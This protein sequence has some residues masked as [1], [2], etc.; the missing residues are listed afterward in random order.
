MGVGGLSTG[1]ATGIDYGSLLEGLLNLEQR[2]I[3]SLEEKINLNNLKTEAYDELNTQ[4][5]GAKLTMFDFASLSTFEKKTV[6]SSNESV[7]TASADRTAATGSHTLQ[8]SRLASSSVSVSDGVKDQDTTTLNAG[9]L[10]FELG[11]RRLDSSM[12]LDDLNDGQGIQRGVITLTDSSGRS[13]N[14]DLASAVT[15]QDMLDLFNSNGMGLTISTDRSITAAPADP[16]ANGY[17]LQVVNGSSNSVTLT[18]I[19][20]SSTL[21]DLGFKTSTSKTIGA[22]K[23]SS[24]L[25]QIHYLTETTKLNQVNDGFGILTNTSGT[26]DMRFYVKNAVTSSMKAIEVDLSS[27]QNVGDVVN[28]INSALFDAQMNQY[29]TARL[30]SDGVSL[31]FTGE[32][33]GFT[34]INE[35]Q[36]ATDLGLDKIEKVGTVY[37]GEALI[38]EMGSS[39]IRNLKGGHGIDGL[40]TGTFNITSKRG[41]VYSIQLDRAVNVSDI[42]NEINNAVANDNNVSSLL[43]TMSF[44]ATNTMTDSTN[45]IS[46]S[47]TIETDRLIGAQVLAID[48]LGNQYTAT[49][50]SID[51]NTNTITF[52]SASDQISAVSGSVTQYL[53]RYQN[54]SDIR[55]EINENG[56]G[57]SI[58]DDSSGNKTFRVDDI[59]GNVAKQLGI[60]TTLKITPVLF[61]PANIGTDTSGVGRRSALYL[62]KGSLPD[63]ITEA[64][65]LGRSVENVWSSST[66]QG[67]SSTAFSETKESAKIIAFEKAPDAFSLSPV[68]V[69]ASSTVS[70]NGAT[71]TTVAAAT[72]QT[73][74]YNDGEDVLVDITNLTTSLNTNLNTEFIVGSTVSVYHPTNGIVSS[75]VI[76]YDSTAKSLTFADDAFSAAGLTASDFETY[77]YNVEYN[78]KIVLEH[79]RTPDT[80]SSPSNLAVAANSITDTVTTANNT[81]DSDRVNGATM[82][83]YS[84]GTTTESVITGYT[85]VDNGDGT[86]NRSFTLADTNITDLGLAAINTAGFTVT[87]TPMQ[88]ANFSETQSNILS[89]HETQATDTI[90]I[91]GVGSG[92]NI[93]GKNLDNRMISGNT[94]LDD[95]NGGKGINKGIMVISTGDSNAEIDLNQA[96]IQ[97]VQDLINEVTNKFASV[98]LEIND[99]GDGLRIYDKSTSPT[100]GLSVTDKTGTAAADLNLLN[101][102]LA[103]TKLSVASGQDFYSLKAT[104][105][106]L[107]NAGNFITQVNATGLGQQNKSDMI[108]SKISY[109]DSSGGALNGKTIHAIIA[110][111]S[112]NTSTSTTTFTLSGQST[113]SH[114]AGIISDVSQ[115]TT[116]TSSTINI[117]DTL[118]IR[119]KKHFSDFESFAS[120]TAAAEITLGTDGSATP[121]AMELTLNNSTITSYANLSEEDLIGSM[122]NFASP[123]SSPALQ[124]GGGITA[125]IT[126]FDSANNKLYVQAADADVA[127][128]KSITNSG[129]DMSIGIS[130]DN[131]PKKHIQ[132]GQI[133]NNFS[134]LKDV[135]TKGYISLTAQVTGGSSNVITSDQ[136]AN[137]NPEDV[138]GALVTVKTRTSSTTDVGKVA[139][140]TGYNAAAKSVTVGNY[141]TYD[142]TTGAATAGA[143]TLSA[144]DEIYVTYAK[145]LEGAV[146]RSDS[147]TSITQASTSVSAADP[148]N[149]KLLD[150]GPITTIAGSEDAIIGATITFGSA[151]TTTALQNE[152]RKI[153]DILHDYG[154]TAGNTVLVLD[155]ALPAA[156]NIT[157]ASPFTDETFIISFNEITATIDEVDFSTGVISTRE[158]LE[159]GFGTRGFSIHQ[160]IDGSY[161]KEIEVLETDTLDDLTARINGANM[162]VRASVI[163]DGSSSNPFRLSLTSENTGDRGAVTVSSD[164]SDF[165]LNVASKGQDAKIIIGDAAGNSSVVTSSTNTVTGAIA[166]VTLNLGQAS[167]EQVSLT[168]D[169]DKEGLQEKAQTL[170]D[171][172]NTLLDSASKLIALE[173]VVEVTQ[174]DGTVRNE[175]QKGLLFGDAATR[176]M[177]NDIKSLLT[178]SVSG[179]ASG[180]LNELSDVGITLASD[181]KSF[182]FDT[183][184]FNSML[185]SKFDEVTNLFTTNPNLGPGASLNV[186]SSFLQSNYNINH[187]RNGDTSKSGFSE[188]GN[189]TNGI[190]LQAG[191]ASKY[192]TY[193]FGEQKDLY[194]FRLH[195]YVPSD[196]T[197]RYSVGTNSSTLSGTTLTDLT[198]LGEAKGLNSEQVVGA[199]LTIGTSQATVTGY[200][201]TTGALTLDTSITG[202]STDGYILTTKNGQNISF[203]HNVVVEY[204]DP[205]TNTYKTYQTYNSRTDG[206]MSIVFPGQLQTDSL[207]IRYNANTGDSEDFTNNGQYVRLLEM[208]VLDSQGIGSQFSRTFDNF[209]NANTGSI[210]IANKNLT[211]LNESYTKQIERL[212]SSLN[213]SQDRY[214][215]QFQNLE[216]V[217]SQLNSQSQYLQSQLGSLPTAFSYRGNNG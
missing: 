43:N 185:S 184:L 100:S 204:R 174:E 130:R 2:P 12:L 34:N 5:L 178:A 80:T 194:G 74:I 161:Q 94:R 122:I 33:S 155:E 97:T 84:G 214:I 82:T 147:K 164:I 23:T 145:E 26:N 201:A 107:T 163:S 92:S 182:D 76:K 104:A 159:G 1:L 125:M 51:L 42:L 96:T 177:I 200:N 209:T 197:A 172:V 124:G 216:Q 70:L 215:K 83:V 30:S 105:S 190:K 139:V 109:V 140:I 77:G 207:R 196:L 193:T 189:G 199:T 101:T 36:A 135:T 98:R 146:L 44:T 72:S 175:K 186:S 20:T 75:T 112:Y 65:L 120:I 166:G 6:N 28:A 103:Q 119:L 192:L 208:E 16:V 46:N 205:T 58:S 60:E 87:Y 69:A 151:T 206:V 202:T 165:Q 150:I 180:T 81:I 170:V 8:V 32:V 176:T 187:V 168:I 11:G 99:R 73:S 179:L 24:N 38:A 14:I 148:S 95:L 85:V 93:I 37:K 195:H 79:D 111:Y 123:A 59:S 188:S 121:G 144:D 15:V 49:I 137:L 52:D 203:S 138:I 21:S 157:G 114:Q 71:T 149:L 117:G 152:S 162:G 102:G 63:D 132:A 66:S 126:N 18:E 154:G 116:G 53:I 153:V 40:Q 106:A 169:H 61:N 128:I 113:E 29:S 198:N 27:A 47:T 17:T 141:H 158:E 64:D 213:S 88:F 210:S 160:V 9:K 55:A 3:N 90:S 10:T 67:Q 91:V 127:K 35:S 131:A 39:L 62:A 4:A 211:S 57:I 142:A 108:G 50:E 115:G 86:F 19:G 31:E 68:E 134:Y 143:L 183:D 13:E 48:G 156:M 78:H 22:G 45:L 129:G 118:N 7:L 217:V 25:S 167:K 171:E 54:L 56:N 89:A 110:D 41:D 212:T 191:S 133:S 173:T 136:F 181:G